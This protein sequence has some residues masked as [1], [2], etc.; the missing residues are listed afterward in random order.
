MKN[1]TSCKS[2]FTLIELLVVVLIIGILASIALPQ[3]EMAV[4]KARAT[5]AIVAVKA[6]AEATERYYLAN[7]TYPANEQG[8]QPL[9]KINEELDIE[10]PEIEGL[11]I[12]KHYNTYIGAQ[13]R[14]SSRF[15]YMIAQT[16][17]QTNY[18]PFKR[19][20]TCNTAVNNDTSRSARLCQQLCKTDTLRQ[21]WG[22]A[23]SGCEL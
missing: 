22:S 21:I 4:E 1:K 12:F 23:S 11:E 16:M 13:R 17:K 15:S 9:S 3:Y 7:G 18:E 14:G 2:G 6:L 5:K 8:K 20:M 19:G 10:V